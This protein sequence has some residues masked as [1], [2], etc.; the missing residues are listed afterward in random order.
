MVNLDD[1]HV[2]HG[3]VETPK[4]LLGIHGGVRLRITDLLTGEV[5]H[6]FND[7]NYVELRPAKQAAHLFAVEFLADPVE[8]G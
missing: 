1:Q 8:N 5:Y 6:W 3:Y 2:Q 7:W 4:A